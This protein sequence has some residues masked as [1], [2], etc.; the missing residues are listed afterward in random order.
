MPKTKVS[1]FGGIKI[2]KGALRKWLKT[3][4]GEKISMSLLRK[5]ARQPVGTKT[6][7]GTLTAHRKRQVNLAIVFK[8]TKKI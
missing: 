8:K 5:L 7:Y 6:K 3:P 2:T 1:I 4:K